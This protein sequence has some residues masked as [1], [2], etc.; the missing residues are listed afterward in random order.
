M[1]GNAHGG[2]TTQGITS[3]PSN[4]QFTG[5]INVHSTCTQHL[6]FPLSRQQERTSHHHAQLNL[7]VHPVCQSDSLYG[8]CI[9]TIDVVGAEAADKAF[10]Q[11]QILPVITRCRTA[12]RNKIQPLGTSFACQQENPLLH[13]HEHIKQR[14]SSNSAWKSFSDFAIRLCINMLGSCL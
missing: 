12:C 9:S 11:Q 4:Q 1:S 14:Q 8:L 2:F 7:N 5:S 13:R 3:L 10:P 6:Q